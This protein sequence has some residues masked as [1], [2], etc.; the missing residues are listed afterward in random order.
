[1]DGARELLDIAADYVQ[2][3][4]AHEL[5]EANA[6]PARLDVIAERWEQALDAYL[7]RG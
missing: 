4:S 6:D 3:R 1:M 7:N 5:D 2:Q